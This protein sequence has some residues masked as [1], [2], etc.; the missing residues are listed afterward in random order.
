MVSDTGAAGAE[1]IAKTD[2]AVRVDERLVRPHPGAEQVEIPRRREPAGGNDAQNV[3][4]GRP[5]PARVHRPRVSRASLVG[6][7]DVHPVTVDRGRRGRHLPGPAAEVDLG[8]SGEAA[9]VQPDLGSDGGLVAA[10]AALETLDVS[11][12]RRSGDGGRVATRGGAERDHCGDGAGESKA[13][14]VGQGA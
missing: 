2:A 7:D 8:G 13:G 9:T 5:V 6:N 1:A 14:E 11:G 3:R 10:G 4:R 12:P